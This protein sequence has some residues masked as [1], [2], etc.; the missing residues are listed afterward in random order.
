MHSRKVRK[1][2]VSKTKNS[3]LDYVKTKFDNKNLKKIK[4]IFSSWKCVYSEL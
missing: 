4:N 2:T 1:I 3:F